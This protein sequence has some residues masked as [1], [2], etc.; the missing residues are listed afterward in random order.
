MSLFVC[1]FVSGEDHCVVNVKAS[2]IGVPGY[3]SNSGERNPGF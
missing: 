2:H 1:L 3:G